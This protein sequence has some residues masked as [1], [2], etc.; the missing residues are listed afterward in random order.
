[1][2][3]SGAATQAPTS[4]TTIAGRV[5]LPSTIDY[6]FFQEAQPREPTQAEVDALMVQTNVFYLGV[7]SQSYAN[8]EGFQAER[9]FDCRLPG[10]HF[11]HVCPHLLLSVFSYSYD[12]MAPWPIA[13]DFDA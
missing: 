9:T 6:R 2:L 11:C 3:S 13:V 5:V 10:Q 12:E 7:M 4:M 8:L 1:M